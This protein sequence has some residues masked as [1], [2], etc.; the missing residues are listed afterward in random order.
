[1]NPIPYY[2]LVCHPSD[3]RMKVFLKAY[4]YQSHFSLVYNCIWVLY[5]LYVLTFVYLLLMAWLPFQKHLIY[6]L[7]VL[8]CLT[9]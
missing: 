9:L 4:L 3:K 6:L 8:D 5:L 1:M 2:V 7:F